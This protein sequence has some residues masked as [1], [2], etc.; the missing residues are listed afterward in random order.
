MERSNSSKVVI[1]GGGPA[2]LT[3]AY[4]LSKKG[5][6]SVVFEKDQAVGG[7][8]K[9]VNY[10]DYHFDLGGHRFFTKVKKVDEMWRD[11]LRD[12]F[13]ERK[14]L[15]RIYYNKK[16][17]YYPL[18]PMNALLGLGVWNSF[19]IFTSYLYAHAFPSKEEETFDQWVSNRF[20][21]RLYRTFFKTYTEKVWGI[22]CREIRAEWAAQRIKGLSLISALRNAIM[23]SQGR[24][25]KQAVI[26]TLIDRF[27]Y[28][29]YGPGMMWQTVA[30]MVQ[31]KGSKVLTG[32]DV[33]GILWDKERVN[34]VEI[35]VDGRTER[36]RGDA[37]I[38]SMP[39]RELIQKLR[40]RVP[41]AVLRAADKLNYRDFL[42]VALIVNKRDVFPDN[43]IYIHDPGVKLGRIQN[44]KNWS[45]YMVPDSEKTCL[46]LEYFCF[47][48][49]ELWSMS[50]QELIELGKREVEELGLV[51]A[52]DVVDG[53]VVRMPK[54]YPVYDSNYQE[55]LR[56]IRQFLDQIGNLQIVGRNGMHKYNNQDHSMLTAM[57]AV[58]NLSGAKHNLW[59]V[60][61]EQEYLE[62]KKAIPDETIV[63]AFSRMD[64]LGFATAIGSVAGMLMLIATLWLVIKGGEVIGPNLQLL[65][66]YFIGYTVTVK[67]AF[68]GAAYSF[69]WAFLSGWL[70]AYLRNLSLAFFIYRAKRKA[71]LLSFKDFLDHF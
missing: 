53:K 42:T 29:K 30:D 25:G 39:M 26:K 36:V 7:I 59:E 43:W 50:D 38:S 22:S 13:I 60:N 10:K 41:E 44:F 28:P 54:A 8:S 27:D 70:F 20:G 46:G 61:E 9:T 69:V 47:E 16:F 40:P 48:G 58:E 18:R 31:K 14:R 2:G 23:S 71:A 12:D 56:I 63:R 15:S 55:S 4:E 35:S 51:E 64:K 3:A 66:Q 11:V 67:G 45:P 62:E 33:E 19:L 6:E 1:I 17:F 57:L 24:E 34:A 37:F 32:A 21:E 65:G 52:R 49:D 68:I 5:V